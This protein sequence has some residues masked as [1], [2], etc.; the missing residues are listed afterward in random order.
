MHVRGQTVAG[1]GREHR[2]GSGARVHRRDGQRP[3][4]RPVGPAGAAQLRLRA[5]VRVHGRLAAGRLHVAGHRVRMRDHRV[6]RA[7]PAAARVAVLPDA[8]RAAGRGG[9][10]SVRAEELRARRPAS[11]ARRRQE[12]GVDRK[13]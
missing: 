1:G 10:L 5:A 2:M 3:D 9:P 8:G 7:V 4:T 12:L 11:R 6:R 13:V